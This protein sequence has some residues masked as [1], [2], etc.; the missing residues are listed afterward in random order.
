[1]KLNKSIIA[2]IKKHDEYLDAEYQI[3]YKVKY[4][5]DTVKAHM[6]SFTDYQSAISKYHKWYN[7]DN[8]TIIKE[9]HTVLLEHRAIDGRHTLVLKYNIVKNLTSYDDDFVYQKFDS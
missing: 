1:M 7:P 5:D 8:D 6:L 9:A 2:E 4:M 3:F